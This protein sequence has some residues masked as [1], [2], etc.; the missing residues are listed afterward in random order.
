ML[1]NEASFFVTCCAVSKLRVVLECCTNLVVEFR[2]LEHLLQVVRNL[3]HRRQS[4][5][6]AFWQWKKFTGL[7]SLG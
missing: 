1:W 4:G 5:I 2:I 6:V 7:I 3:Q